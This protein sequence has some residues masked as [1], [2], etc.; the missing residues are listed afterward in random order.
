MFRARNYVHKKERVVFDTKQ[1][2]WELFTETSTGEKVMAVF[3]SCK[4]FGDVMEIEDFQPEIM[5]DNGGGNDDDDVT[6]EG[7]M[8]KGSDKK[9]QNKNMGMDFV[10]NIIAFSL[11]EEVSIVILVTDYMTIHALK[12]I[13]MLPGLTISH[14]TYEETGIEHMADHISQPVVFR[15]L[16]PTDRRAYI[17]AHP[18]YRIEL[19]RYSVSDTLVKY[20]GM[21]LDDIIYIE[22][23]DRQTGLV[24]EY[25]LVVEEL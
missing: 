19:P 20:Y 8:F 13:D 16:S 6:S 24:V 23:N 12:H 2:L 17:K 7:A 5:D 14:F 21:K 22:D 25:A 3:A 11:K 9:S 1:K 18:R 4:P 10:K 15:P